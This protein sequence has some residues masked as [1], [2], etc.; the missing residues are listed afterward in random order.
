[1]TLKPASRQFL[2]PVNEEYLKMAADCANLMPLLSITHRGLEM[3]SRTCRLGGVVMIKWLALMMLVV[4]AGGC[5][6]NPSNLPWYDRPVV[7]LPEAPTAPP[8]ITPPPVTP[9][10]ESASPDA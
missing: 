1:M 10:D 3:L 4:L 5:A 9:P 6:S 2:M 7:I 8:P